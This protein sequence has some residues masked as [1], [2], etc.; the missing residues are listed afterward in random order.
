MK[1]WKPVEVEFTYEVTMHHDGPRHFSLIVS[2]PT[3]M[4]KQSWLTVHD[5]WGRASI[6]LP[7]SLRLC[8]PS[9]SDG[10]P[11]GER[12]DGML[13]REAMAAYSH[14]AWSQWMRYL[15]SKTE[16]SNRYFSDAPVVTIPDWAVE[17]WTRQMN[18]PYA[19]LPEEEKESDRLEADRIIEVW[20][21]TPPAAEQIP[22]N[23]RHAADMLGGIVTGNVMTDMDYEHL[24]IIRKWI[25]G[26]QK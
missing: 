17:R 6:P 22:A 19:D 8:K 15:F 1:T 7:D 2:G 21:K 18:T 12:A 5:Y 4:L 9:E 16:T 3:S 11:V 14:E 20:D 23:V 24:S 13:L 26:L 10:A 25:R